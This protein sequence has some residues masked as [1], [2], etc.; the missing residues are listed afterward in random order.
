[1]RKRFNNS[2][3]VKIKK[4]WSTKKKVGVIASIVAG[5]LVLAGVGFLVYNQFFANNSP[6]VAKT[7][8]P[9]RFF[10]PLTGIETTEENTKRP[11]TAVMIENSPEARP[12]SGLQEAGVVFEAVAEGGITRFIALYQEAQPALIGPV[13]SVRPYY[14]EWAAGFDPAIAHVGGSYEAL[15]MTRG[16]AYG[17]DIDEF[18]NAHVFWRATDRYAPHNTYTNTELLDAFMAANGKT[19]SSFTAWPRTNGEQVTPPTPSDDEDADPVVDAN[20]Y[21]H[22]IV[23]P[24]STG[25]FQVSYDY[26]ADT[27]KYIR[28]Q[29]GQA[30]LDR[31]KGQ[32]APDTVVAMMVNMYLA[33]DGLHNE[34]GIIGSGAAYIFQNGIMTKANWSKA[35]ATAQA[36]FTD[37]EGEEIKFNRGQTWFTAVPNSHTVTWQ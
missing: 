14:V 3:P 28:Y 12:Q 20:T 33:N 8:E 15:Q 2:H 30:H 18:F 29:G 37:S 25:Q 1:M 22:S 7:P 17:L 31:E 10:S 9:V 21:A 32:I 36:K 24:V 23:M 19:S 26:D 4:P 27:N 11:V 35:S 34:I 5:V 6:E 13:R 16:G